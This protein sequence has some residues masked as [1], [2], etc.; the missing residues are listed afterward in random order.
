M[1]ELRPFALLHTRDQW[2]RAAHDDT[3]IDPDTGGVTLAWEQPATVDLPGVEAPPPPGGLAFDAECRLYHAVPS[4]GRVERVLWAGVDPLGPRSPEREPLDLFERTPEDR[5]GEFELPAAASAP[6]VDPRGLAVDGD[7]RL[8]VAEAGRRTVLVFDLWSR[9]LLR[10]VALAPLGSGPIPL[11]L[12]ADGRTV[13]VLVD[14]PPGLVRMK[15][16]GAVERRPLSAVAANV[17]AGARPV[18]LAVSPRGDLFVLLRDGAGETWIATARPRTVALRVAGATDLEFLDAETLV[19][20]RR[21]GETFAVFRWEDGDLLAD[22]PLAARGYDGGGIVRTPD[23]RIGFWTEHGLRRAVAARL[24]YVDRGRVTTYRL[25]SGDF[26]TEW[27]RLFTDACIP[28]GTDVR[29]HCR[30]SD[31]PDAERP[32]ARTRPSNAVDVIVHRP[33]LSPSMPDQALA[34]AEGE[35][36]LPLHRRIGRELPW[37]RPGPDHPFE[38][39]EAPVNAPP[40]RYLWVTL[41]LYGT[42]R[43]TPQVRS[44]RAERPSHD[45]VRRLPRAF[46]REEQVASFLRRYLAMA[47]GTLSELASRSDAR[48]TLVDPAATPEEALPWLASFLGLALDERWPPARRRALIA[49]GT[50]LFRVRGTVPG[51]RRFLEL[52][53]GA[54]IVVIEHFR[55][56]GIGGLL[57]RESGEP[58]EDAAILGA[59]FRVGGRVGVTEEQVRAPTEDAFEAHAHRF[60][61]VIGAVL[62]DE[63]LAMVRDVL[64]VHRP[65]HT[66]VDVCTV[67]A[68]MRVGRG[69]HLGLMSTIG[70]T[71]AMATVQLGEAVLGRGSVLGRAEPGTVPGA[72]RLGADSRVG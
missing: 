61:V 34:P 11:D 40:G 10:R 9:R 7:D 17:P 66:V 14:R 6:L 60:T 56:R 15:A 48:R 27:G 24:R 8:F 44:L 58:G 51:L 43:V 59:G 4:G 32:L 70:P 12:A 64:D 5:G 52:C 21:P 55:L 46:S 38:T 57:G 53:V 68:G 39:Y 49:E 62:E 71:G 72:S 25:D 37:S 47:D 18:R 13:W 20:A 69:L 45:L 65:A 36:G 30:T 2:M 28:Q 41:D 3:F 42:T 31:E 29:V 19:V 23:G 22:E 33:D 50:R 67:G 16:R 1:P 26:Q 54:P 63:Q 35:E